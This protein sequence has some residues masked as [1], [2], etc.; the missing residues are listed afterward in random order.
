MTI[1]S[2]SGGRLPGCHF[3]ALMPHSYSDD[4]AQDTVND[5]KYPEVHGNKHD[6]TECWQEEEYS[7]EDDR[8]CPGN[9]KQRPVIRVFRVE[10]SYREIDTSKKEQK[11]GN[12]NRQRFGSDPPV[13]DSGNPD[14]QAEDTDTEEHNGSRCTGRGPECNSQ[15]K[16]TMPIAKSKLTTV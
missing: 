6:C 4:N 10:D 13:Q 3:P 7:P 1:V 5:G 9:N 15:R 16:E 8:K 2:R 14:N 11:E 12:D